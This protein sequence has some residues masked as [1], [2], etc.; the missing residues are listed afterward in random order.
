MLLKF[1]NIIHDRDLIDKFR[2]TPGFTRSSQQTAVL[3]V[4][5]FQNN[6][7]TITR[8]VVKRSRI[9]LDNSLRGQGEELVCVGVLY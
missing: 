8:V 1:S 4:S 5:R 6:V 3:I 7:R 2:I 9:D